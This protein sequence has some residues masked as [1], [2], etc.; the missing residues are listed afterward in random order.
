MRCEIPEATKAHTRTLFYFK[1]EAE[2]QNG[3]NEVR[4]YLQS[5]KLT[6][7]EAPETVRFRTPAL[8]RAQFLEV[9]V[10]VELPTG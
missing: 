2:V 9:G 7:L 6:G 1:P 8:G 3:H 4:R 10:S 5:W